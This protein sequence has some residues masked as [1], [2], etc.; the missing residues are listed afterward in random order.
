MTKSDKEAALDEAIKQ[1]QKK[2][3]K[4]AILEMDSDLDFKV[5]SIPTGCYQLD[6][7][8]GCGGLPKGRII[9]IY[10]NPSEGKSTLA[11]F[12]MAQVQKSG[13]KAALIDAEFSFNSDY[14]KDIGI[15]TSKLI[16]A[17]PTTLEE[18]VDV[19]DKLVNS[20][21]VDIIVVDS[22]ASMVPKKE[23]EGEEMLA[24]SIAMQARLMNKALRILT[25]SV[26]KSK[27]VLIFINQVRDQIGVFYGAKTYT[28]G[29]KA[30]KFYASI[31]LEV[32]RGDKIM[33]GEAQ[34]GNWLKVTVV[35]NKV[36][37][38]WRKAEFE[39]Y[40]NSGID[41]IG[42][43]LDFAIDKK[44]IGKDGNTY[45]TPAGEKLGVGR[46]KAKDALTKNPE[47]AEIIRQ[48]LKKML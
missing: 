40:Y 28:P 31:R 22:V 26:S 41:M 1:L 2:F 45:T 17:Q 47:L 38:P 33:A 21:A 10:G 46:D 20:Q 36:G 48:A 6:E 37:F 25:G 42:S 27:T 30:L 39:L 35:K 9:E 34:I 3:G 18:A 43:L 16:V 7:A 32:K 23:L 5:E 14:A 11:M 12:F 44:V 4:T 15:D 19:I 13:G 24:D 8:L 29:G